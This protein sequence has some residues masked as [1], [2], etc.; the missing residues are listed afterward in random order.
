[1]YLALTDVRE[2][3]PRIRQA[4]SPTRPAISFGLRCAWLLEFAGEQLRLLFARLKPS[5]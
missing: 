2:T 3:I 1:M 5:V 4:L